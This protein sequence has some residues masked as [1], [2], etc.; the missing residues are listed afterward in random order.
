MIVNDVAWLSLAVTQIHEFEEIVFIEPFLRR[1]R[2]DPRSPQLPFQSSRGTSTSTIAFN[3]GLNFVLFTAFTLVA[4]IF[5]WYSFLWGFLVVF[6]LHLVG[7]VTETL[8]LRRYTPSTVTGFATLPW[9]LYAVWYLP[10]YHHVRGP[11]GVVA[12]IAMMVVADIDLR[13]LHGNEDRF[14]AWLG[15]VFGPPD[16]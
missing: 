1:T 5:N 2:D 3:I 16:R 4:V 9:M 7:H 12:L 11:S 6:T 14:E 13:F 8:R 15:R 10:H